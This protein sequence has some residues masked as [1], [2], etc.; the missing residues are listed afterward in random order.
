MNNHQQGGE[1]TNY[2][3][4]DPE[5]GNPYGQSQQQYGG[6]QQYGQQQYDA[7]APQYSEKPMFDQAFKLE[8]PKYNDLW[9]AILFILVCIGFVAVSGLAIHGYGNSIS[10]DNSIISDRAY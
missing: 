4:A 8:R 7:P 10:L 3:N 5:R 6:P 9:A 2:Y 1:A